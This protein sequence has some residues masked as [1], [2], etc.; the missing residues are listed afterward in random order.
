MPSEYA[1]SIECGTICQLRRWAS[2]LAIAGMIS[3]HA[4]E[5][6][7]ANVEDGL[8]VVHANADQGQ[9]G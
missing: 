9:R 5:R 7:G 2:K 3:D 8:Q 1:P 4:G 6:K